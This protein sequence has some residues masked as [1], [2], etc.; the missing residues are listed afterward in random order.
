MEQNKELI[1]QL[2][3]LLR[4]NHDR[5]EGYEKAASELKDLSESEFKTLFFKMAEESRRYASTLTEAVLRLG[6]DP[7]TSTSTAGDI[8]R[9]WMDV[10][11]AFAGDDLLATLRACEFGEDNAL[12]AYRT[13]ISKNK[14]WPNGTGEIIEMQYESLKASHDKIKRLRDEQASVESKA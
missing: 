2:N 14:T 8:Y 9:V 11:V 4:I 13:V 5:I 6:G 3:D 12:K 10:K 1:G 7:E